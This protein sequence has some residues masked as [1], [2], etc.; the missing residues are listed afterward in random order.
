MIP[1][2]RQL[3]LTHCLVFVIVTY[4]EVSDIL[5]LAEV[6][7]SNG[8]LVYYLVIVGYRSLLLLWLKLVINGSGRD[9]VSFIQMHCYFFT[10]LL[11]VKVALHSQLQPAVLLISTL[12]LCHLIYEYLVSGSIVLNVPYISNLYVQS[13]TRWTTLMSNLGILLLLCIAIDLVYRV[14]LQSNL[15]P[16]EVAINSMGALSSLLYSDSNGLCV[17]LMI[18]LSIFNLTTS[19]LNLCALD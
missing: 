1:E 19:I 5:F 9:F 8:M 6:S 13:S 10:L 11:F 3:V 14:S 15:F 7:S 17:W 16:G 18:G 2:K 4:L 12:M